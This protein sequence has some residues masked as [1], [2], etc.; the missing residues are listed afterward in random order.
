MAAF[1]AIRSKFDRCRPEVAGDVISD[2]AVERSTIKFC[3]SKPKRSRD[4]RAAHF[5]I[6]N[7]DERRR[8]DLVV[9]G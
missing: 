8:T 1:S 2:V 4:I 6:D 9:L 5:V 7:D 3:A